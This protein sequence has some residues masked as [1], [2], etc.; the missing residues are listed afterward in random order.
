MLGRPASR[1]ALAALVNPMRLRAR[2][3]PE[4][5][6]EPELEGGTVSKHQVSVPDR[7]RQTRRLL[8]TEGAAGSSDRLRRRGAALLAPSVVEAL[9]VSR[10]DLRRAAAAVAAGG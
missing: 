3:G 2:P 7:L 5:L 4:W 10:E 8:R 6:R 9:P 1:A